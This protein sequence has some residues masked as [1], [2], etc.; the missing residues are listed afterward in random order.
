MNSDGRVA[1]NAL[2]LQQMILSLVFLGKG[3]QNNC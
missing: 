3:A 1:D 2:Q